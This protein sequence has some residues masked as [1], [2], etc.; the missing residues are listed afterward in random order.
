MSP[1]HGREDREGEERR[2]REMG[3][4]RGRVGGEKGK[5]AK[6]RRRWC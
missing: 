4:G 3:V 2:G 6:E 5:R 1:K